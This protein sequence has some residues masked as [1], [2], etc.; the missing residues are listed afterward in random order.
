MT[1]WMAGLVSLGLV[2][3]ATPSMA[4]DK[5][6]DKP[7]TVDPSGTW[8]WEYELG[9]QTMKDSLRLNLSKDTTVVGVYQGRS[10][11]A[12]EIK[13]GKI[14]GDKLSFHFSVDYQGT[15]I[16]LEFKGK[17]N[18]DDIEGTVAAT[19]S[20]GTRDFPWTPKRSVTMDDVVGKWQ[21]RIDANGNILVPV[22]TIAKDGDKF[23][24][25]YVS[26]EDIKLEANNMKIENNEL[27]FSISGEVRGTKIKADYRG[28][29]Y[30][31]KIKGIIDYELGDNSGEIDFTG[32]RKS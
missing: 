4:Q 8:R 29:P 18:K 11:K 10:E 16:K 2:L 28:R 25:K 19:T 1:K 15:D 24:G 27:R 14:E 20:E 6:K 31:D 32:N 30:G 23:T 5:A 22:I 9:G 12:I 17:I 3:L 7:A 13:D 21:L 26:G